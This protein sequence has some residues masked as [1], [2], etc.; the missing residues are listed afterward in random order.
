MY[1]CI[2]RIDWDCVVVPTTLT[3]ATPLP[4]YSSKYIPTLHPPGAIHFLIYSSISTLLLSDIRKHWEC[5]SPCQ[6]TTYSNCSNTC[7]TQV[8]EVCSRHQYTQKK[9]VFFCGIAHCN[10][11]SKVA[12]WQQ[13]SQD[14]LLQPPHSCSNSSVKFSVQV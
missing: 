8:S 5:Q 12:F 6:K 9:F 13:C 14:C 7:Y 1:N 2:I 3:M 10:S 4:Y 11:Y